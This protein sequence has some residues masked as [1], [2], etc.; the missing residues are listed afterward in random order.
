MWKRPS[1]PPV[2]C[3][4]VF[5]EPNR[6]PASWWKGLTWRKW[7][8]SAPALPKPSSVRWVRDLSEEHDVGVNFIAVEQ[9]RTALHPVSWLDPECQLGNRLRKVHRFF[10]GEREAR[11]VSLNHAGTAAQQSLGGAFDIC[12]DE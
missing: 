6:W 11:T 7:K 4:C 1:A 10:R 9:A 3:W 12:L 2:A 5:P 8:A